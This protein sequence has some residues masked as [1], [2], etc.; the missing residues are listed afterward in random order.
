MKGDSRTDANPHWF[1]LFYENWS[2]L[3]QGSSLTKWEGL[4]DKVATD[5]RRMELA[6]KLSE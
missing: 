6:N 3:T 4:R 1:P 5:L 2:D